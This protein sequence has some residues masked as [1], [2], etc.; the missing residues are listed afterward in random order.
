MYNHLISVTN[1]HGREGSIIGDFGIAVCIAFKHDSNN[2]K[3]IQGW[4]QLLI[5][6]GPNLEIFLSDLRKLFKRD[7][8]FVVPKIS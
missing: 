6:G 5:K 7:K 8:F 2:H 4:I 1:A 3:D